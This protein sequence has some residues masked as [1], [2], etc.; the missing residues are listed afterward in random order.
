M[1]ILHRSF[2]PGALGVALLIAGPAAAQEPAAAS[3]AQELA[4]AAPA[5]EPAAASAAQEP[6]A[7]EP[8]A[9]PNA[10][11][12]S[13]R[14]GFR[15]RTADDRFELGIGGRLQFDANYFSDDEPFGG[16]LGRVEDGFEV[17]RARIHLKGYYDRIEYMFEL[18]FAG[19]EVGARDMYLGVRGLPMTAR[20]GYMKEPYSLEELVS[21]RFTTFMERSLV[22]MFAPGR[23]TGFGFGAGFAGGRGTWAAGLY[24]ET[25]GFEPTPGNNYD[26]AGRVTYAPVL[27]NGG[28]RLVHV[29]AALQHR[30]LG[31][32][33][34]VL[35]TRPGDHN[36]PGIIRVAIPATAAQF[37][38]V[39]AAASHGPFGI[40][41]EYD[42]VW[43]TSEQRGDPTLHGYYAQ[44]HWFITGEHRPYRD[45]KFDRLRPQADFLRGGA[46]ALQI[47]ARFAR[48]DVSEALLEP[49]GVLEVLTVGLNWYWNP[50]LRWML[51]YELADLPQLDTD[52]VSILHWRLAFDF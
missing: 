49:P 14:D 6:A 46:G 10:V 15:L 48:V 22:N 52:K 9:D 19:G 12:V 32:N 34:L 40:Q 3:P 4:A 42:S 11:S 37:L 24:R 38:S 13:F 20:F 2:I 16:L 26:L 47:A 51:N 28:E 8:V 50:Y 5:Q 39:E 31:G 35:S 29:G 45:G 21:S 36:T 25:D 18:D 1:N 30:W 33:L 27:A 7:T 23:Q 44:A 17:R 43:V 41:G